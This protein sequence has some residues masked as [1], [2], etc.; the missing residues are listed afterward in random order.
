M[1]PTVSQRGRHL[2]GHTHLASAWAGDQSEAPEGA[3]LTSL[4]PSLTSAALRLA[5]RNSGKQARE[6]Q[7]GRRSFVHSEHGCRGQGNSVRGHK[8]KPPLCFARQHR[9][10]RIPQSHCDELHSANDNLQR[11]T[12]TARGT[13]HGSCC[14]A[15]QRE[16][17]GTCILPHTLAVLEGFTR[18]GSQLSSAL[19]NKPYIP[20]PH[21]HSCR[22]S[23]YAKA[24]LLKKVL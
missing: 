3:V 16:A 13:W 4:P 23:E 7:Q 8:E 2:T 20:L 14:K 21:E 17:P 15:F 6:V 9:A 10:P 22:N 5:E 12:S 11:K 18:Q 1:T 19:L 24:S